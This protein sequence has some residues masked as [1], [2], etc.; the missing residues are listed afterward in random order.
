[1]AWLRRK[2]CMDDLKVIEKMR[3]RKPKKLSQFLF[4]P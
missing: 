2:R 4:S 3:L 1:M